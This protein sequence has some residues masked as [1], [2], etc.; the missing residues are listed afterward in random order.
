MR[1][2]KQPFHRPHPGPSEG[3]QTH[4]AGASRSRGERVRRNLNAER[5]GN[6]PLHPRASLSPPSSLACLEEPSRGCRT[7]VPSPLGL[8]L[9]P[10]GGTGLGFK[11]RSPVPQLPSKPPA[12]PARKSS[13][14]WVL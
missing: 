9:V 14:T 3:L 4:C 1:N 2:K 6:W 5:A 11:A 8:S 12:V 10:P 7:G 13:E